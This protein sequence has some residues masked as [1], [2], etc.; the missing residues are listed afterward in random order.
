ME[1]KYLRAFLPF[2]SEVQVIAQDI[3]MSSKA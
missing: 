3:G 2:T 1:G